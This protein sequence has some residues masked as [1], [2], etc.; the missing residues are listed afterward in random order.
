MFNMEE[1][2]KTNLI[3]GYWNN[4]FSEQQVNLFAMSYLT[5]G[6]IEQ[7]DFNH[8]MKSIEPPE[9]IEEIQP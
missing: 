4:S 8:I 6:M 3:N 7:E 9:P 2:I 5:K 1:F